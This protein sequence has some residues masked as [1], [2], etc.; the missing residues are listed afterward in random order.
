M[1]PTPK[2]SFTATSTGEYLRDLARPGQILDFGLAKVAGA[3]SEPAAGETLRT[4]GA[5]TDQLTSPGSTLGTVA[6][7]SPEQARAKDLRFGT[8]L[9]SSVRFC[10]RWGLGNFRFAAKVPLTSSMRFSTG[11]RFLHCA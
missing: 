9:F 11:N 6:Y 1:P 4:E 7:M 5:N 8:D 10:T 3:R 2:E